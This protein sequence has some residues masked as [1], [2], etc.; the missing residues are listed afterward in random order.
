VI[1]LW[2]FLLLGSEHGILL[3]GHL[4]RKL[5]LVLLKQF[6]LFRGHLHLMWLLHSM[7]GE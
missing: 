1:H 4:L 6:H 3:L 7:G 2:L 5:L